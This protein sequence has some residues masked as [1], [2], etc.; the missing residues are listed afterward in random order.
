[1]VSGATGAVAVVQGKLLTVR[2]SFFLRPDVLKEVNGDINYL[3]VTM[4]TVG[5]IQIIFGS[6]R[7][8]KLMNF[9]SR[10]TMLGFL[11]G[12]AILILL[13]QFHAFREVRD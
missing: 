12:L 7:L 1:M 2:V 5:I 4:M 13:S 8:S 11:N 10:P 9:V 6:L 3:Y